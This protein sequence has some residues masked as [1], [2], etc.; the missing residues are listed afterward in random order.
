[1]HG[2]MRAL[3]KALRLVKQN[4]EVAMGAMMKFSELDRELAARTYDSM[5]GTFTTNGVVDEET[6][7]NDLDIVRDVLKVTKEVGIERAY[8]F[9][10]ARKA[11]SELTQTGWKP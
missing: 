7:K 6:Q 2:F 4:R 10:F 3:L 9:S 11:D 1:M 8:D 5:I